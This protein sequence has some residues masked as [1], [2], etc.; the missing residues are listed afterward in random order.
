[1][2][3]ESFDILKIKQHFSFNDSSATVKIIANKDNRILRLSLFF[4]FF[5]F[6]P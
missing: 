3:C 1:M 6:I 5:Y 2:I 4:P